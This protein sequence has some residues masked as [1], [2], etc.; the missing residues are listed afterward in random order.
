[1]GARMGTEYVTRDEFD[2]IVKRV[3]SLE[4]DVWGVPGNIESGLTA[5]IQ[6]IM[7]HLDEQDK[8]AKRWNTRIGWIVCSFA[9]AAMMAI[10]YQVQLDQELKDGL[11]K[12]GII[13]QS[14]DKTARN[15]DTPV[16]RN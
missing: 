10:I 5:G 15:S 7:V 3:D 12:A 2:P 1:M 8:S 9:L 6:R 11:H 14:L 16:A 4:L 13:S